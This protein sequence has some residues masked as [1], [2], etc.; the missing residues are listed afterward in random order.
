M[1][2][3]KGWVYSWLSLLRSS[4]LSRV[5][6]VFHRGFPLLNQSL[7][8]AICHTTSKDTVP[9]LTIFLGHIV[10]S[11]KPGRGGARC[12][13]H[14]KLRCRS[15]DGMAIRGRGSSYVS[16]PSCKNRA[17]RDMSGE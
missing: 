10:S 17:L 13:G 3:P 16:D 4:L 5:G 9:T 2:V 14:V 11:S 6:G 15:A 1:S 12:V 7:A 8:A